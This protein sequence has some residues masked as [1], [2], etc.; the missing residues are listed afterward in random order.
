M[1]VLHGSFCDVVA[2]AA[3]TASWGVINFASAFFS[4]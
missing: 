1:H 4:C 3:V 2:D